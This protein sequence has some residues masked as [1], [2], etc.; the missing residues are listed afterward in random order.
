MSMPMPVSIDT[1]ASIAAPM[2][3]PIPSSSPTGLM[4]GSH[5]R[6]I[7]PPEP[8]H[9]GQ[10]RLRYDLPA[11]EMFARRMYHSFSNSSFDSLHFL[12]FPLIDKSSAPPPGPSPISYPPTVIT[13]PGKDIDLGR[14][15]TDP[16]KATHFTLRFTQ[17]RYYYY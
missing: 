7:D 6:M 8:I 14:E 15:F 5:V 9:H 13:G 16:L 4:T 2:P 10:S 11:P 17:F 3:M 1:R 12:L